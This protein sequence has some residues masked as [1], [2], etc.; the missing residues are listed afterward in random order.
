MC[1][2][3]N[4]NQGTMLYVVYFCISKNLSPKI[5]VSPQSFFFFFTPLQIV[6]AVITCQMSKE[7]VVRVW[8]KAESGH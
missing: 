3:N 7:R 1:S 8:A 6:Y 5:L 4:E 2:C